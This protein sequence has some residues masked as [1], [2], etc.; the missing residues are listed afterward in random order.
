MKK[1]VR[2]FNILLKHLESQSIKKQISGKTYD[3][4]IIC[5]VYKGESFY[6]QVCQIPKMHITFSILLL[7]LH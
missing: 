4:E 5:P 3:G 1:G 2:P 7:L 6:V